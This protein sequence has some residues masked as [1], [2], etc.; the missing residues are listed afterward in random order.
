M[1]SGWIQAV[2]LLFPVC[3]EARKFRLGGLGLFLGSS[4]HT[5]QQFLSLEEPANS[6]FPNSGKGFQVH[7]WLPCFVCSPA[8]GLPALCAK[9]A[10]PPPLSAS[11][12]LGGLFLWL[13]GS[14]CF[15]FPARFCSCCPQCKRLTSSRKLSLHWTSSGLNPPVLPFMV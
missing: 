13:D 11:Q 3:R 7:T 2:L 4:P 12:A 1:E 5:V 8:P 6:G 10:G 15:L 14:L 9:Q